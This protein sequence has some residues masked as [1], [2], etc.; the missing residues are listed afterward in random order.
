MRRP[1][2][3]LLL[4]LVVSLPSCGKDT[5]NPFAALTPT[6]PAPAD[7]DIIFTANTWSQDPTA[8]RELFSVRLDGTEVTQLTSCNTGPQS[9]DTI[10]ASVAADRQRAVVL[11]TSG[12]VAGAAIDYLDLARGGTVEFVPA[13]QPSSSI[14]WSPL[15]DELIYSSAAQAG[16][17]EHVIL[18][19]IAR[20]PN[21]NPQDIT[22]TA[23]LPCDPTVVERHPRL[24]D[25]AQSAVFEHAVVGGNSDIIQYTSLGAKVV[26]DAGA[27]GTQPL[28]GT[29][30]FVGGHADPTFSPDT[31]SAV[32]RTLTA[33]GNGTFGSWDIVT[34]SLVGGPRQTIVTGPAYRGAPDWGLKGIVFVELNSATSQFS[35][36]VVQPDGS[37][38]QTV[39]TAPAGFTLSNPRWLF[40]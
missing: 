38:R 27:T 34:A 37:G 5:T 35:I 36:V 1:F 30:Y 19:S 26:V 9:C 12:G 25:E 4:S 18:S 21:N 40:P 33:L 3:L 22:C 23:G 14:D 17:N 32:Y 6:V 39:L 29:P 13:S 11:R 16:A 10:E 20:P 7:A 31:T 15:G 28:P 8:G 24:D 2:R